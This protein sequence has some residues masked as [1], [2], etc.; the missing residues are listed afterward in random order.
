MYVTP[1]TTV[2]FE[3]VSDG[4]NIVVDSQPSGGGWE[5]HEPLE[6]EGFS[7]EFTFETTGVYEYYCTPHQSLGMVGTVEVVEQPDADGDGRG[8]ARGAG[9][10][11]EPRHRLVH[12]DG[13]DPGPRV[14]L[15]E[16]RRR[17]RA[18]RGV[19]PPV[20]RPSFTARERR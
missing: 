19:T 3:W 4:H 1:G 16:V 10:R 15:H 18:A 20:R 5:G 7:Y 6:D 17:L 14:L 2:T 12:R 9:L 8:T 11:E 13:R